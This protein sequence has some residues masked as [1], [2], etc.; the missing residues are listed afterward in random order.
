ML[1]NHNL[2]TLNS[3]TERLLNYGREVESLRRRIT[4]G[5]EM[6]LA[7]GVRPPKLD[8]R[9]FRLQLLIERLIGEALEKY[10]SF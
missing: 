3:L 6:F 10:H 8:S 5:E 4:T 7:T 1:V 9:K 2:Q